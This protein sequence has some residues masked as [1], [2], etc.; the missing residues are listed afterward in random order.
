[1]LVRQHDHGLISGDFARHFA[2]E[3]R[4]LEP[5][6]YAIANHDVAWRTLDTSVRWNEALGRPYSFADYPIEPKLRA[7]EEGL[8][9]LEARSPY[10]ACLCSMYYAAFVGGS[11]GE[12]GVRFLEGEAKR[13]R[14]IKS[15]MTGEELG[16][17]DH[18][19]LLLR[20]CD[21]LS[22]F[23][24]LNEPGQNDHPWYRAGFEFEGERFVPVWEDCSTLRLEPNP[25]SGPF[26]LAIPYTLVG[27]DGRTMGSNRLELGVTC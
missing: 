22:L 15:A 16:N 25:F 26:G 5:T 1:M 9:F 23:V 17:L 4:P 7:Y 3:P 24:C 20:L 6:L 27:K 11:R 8:S 2:E 12:A 13:Q 10:A 19:L 14:E 21:N 18:N